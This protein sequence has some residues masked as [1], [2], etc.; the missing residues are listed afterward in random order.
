MLQNFSPLLYIF[1]L[2]PCNDH[3]PLSLKL[4]QPFPNYLLKILLLFLWSFAPF[5]PCLPLPPTVIWTLVF[6]RISILNPLLFPYYIFYQDDCSYS[7]HKPCCSLPWNCCPHV[8]LMSLTCLL[9]VMFK[10]IFLITAL[11]F[12][13]MIILISYSLFI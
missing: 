1:P 11:I 2:Y 3:W 13:P 8:Y 6:I 5:L 4:C 10:S 12:H 9:R 7:S